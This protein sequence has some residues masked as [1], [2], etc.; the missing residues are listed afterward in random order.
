M[1]RAGV[2]IKDINW[3]RASSSDG[4][5]AI[6][7]TSFCSKNLLFVIPPSIR[8]LSFSLEKLAVTLAAKISSSE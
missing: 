4:N 5:S 6:S 8:S 2:W 1:F 3:A 7:K